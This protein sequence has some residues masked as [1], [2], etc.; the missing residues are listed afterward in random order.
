MAEYHNRRAS[1]ISSFTSTL[2]STNW[3]YFPVRSHICHLHNI[4]SSLDS[5]AHV[6]V[7]VGVVNV[8]F[9]LFRFIYSPVSVSE[10]P[11]ERAH[12]CAHLTWP[13]EWMWMVFWMFRISGLSCPRRKMNAHRHNNYFFCF[14]NKPAKTKKI[15]IFLLIW[16]DIDVIPS[17]NSNSRHSNE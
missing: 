17:R 15:Y 1:I 10:Q 13:F 12:A 16:S 5:R 4:S 14:K 6:C 9:R 7:A 11:R 3:I 8:N 2:A